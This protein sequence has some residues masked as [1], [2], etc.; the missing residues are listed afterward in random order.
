M[1]IQVSPKQLGHWFITACA[2]LLVRE[3]E[4]V[5]LSSILEEFR[6]PSLSLTGYSDSLDLV[7]KSSSLSVEV[8]TLSGEKINE[9][10]YQ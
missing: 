1:C 5:L 3:W 10:F 7:Q 9:D 6:S 8:T 4:P 2:K